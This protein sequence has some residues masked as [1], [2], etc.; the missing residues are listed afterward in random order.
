MKNIDDFNFELSYS[1]SNYN[2]KP[3]SEEI[4]HMHFIHCKTNVNE[5]VDKISKGYAY[6]AV[7]NN[8][9][10]G[11]SL[12]KDS[13]FAYTQVISVDIDKTTISL[14]EAL[15]TLKTTPTMAYNT[16]SNGVNDK[17]CYRLVYIFENHIDSIK[18]A[19]LYTLALN[20]I[21]GDELNIKTDSNA[22]KVSQYF[23]G[24]NDSNIFVSDCIYELND[25]KLDNN[26]INKNNYN[27]TNNKSV[28]PKSYNNNTTISTWSG[29]FKNDTTLI[30]D[31]WILSLTDFLNKYNSIMPNIQNSKIDIPSD[32]EPFIDIPSDYR[33]IKRCWYLLVDDNG[34]K[35]DYIK[36][37]RDGEG[38]RK[39]LFLNGIIRRLINP[40]IT[41]DNM[42]HNIVWEFVIYMVNDGNKITKKILWNIVN[43]IM[44]ADLTSYS[45]L[46]TTSRKWKVNPYFALKHNMS[47]REVINKFKIGKNNNKKQ[48]IGEF[49]DCSLTDKENIEIMKDYGLEI[50]PRTLKRWRK[51]NNITKYKK[52]YEKDSNKKNI[53]FDSK[54][55]NG[56][57][58]ITRPQDEE[59]PIQGKEMASTSIVDDIDASKTVD[60]RFK[61][62]LDSV[63][64]LKKMGIAI[65]RNDIL[66]QK[67][68]IIES[69]KKEGFDKAVIQG[70]EAKIDKY[71]KEYGEKNDLKPSNEQSGIVAHPS[72]EKPTE[73]KQMPS[74]GKELRYLDRKTGKQYDTEAEAQ[75]DGANPMFL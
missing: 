19:K 56:S 38:R 53:K 7:Y 30:N 50:S 44:K 49:Y 15:K 60:G 45:T 51:E 74:N 8:D 39:K 42:L 23:N 57:T 1:D 14:N 36:K 5:F 12:K 72:E 13:N 64:S 55:S 71:I 10:F 22:S 18:D 21:V 75:N 68:C 17:Y 46:G 67:Y 34:R 20:K 27:N 9:E 41:F 54:P 43:D 4:K 66:F 58:L 6:C 28:N 40:Q 33:E 59:N 2:A 70:L 16:F 25:F 26:L 65:T 11:I 63:E 73:A 52:Q 61:I 3:T 35:L 31:F 47:K 37:I 29:T 24:T 69:C 48:F 62:Y 32:D